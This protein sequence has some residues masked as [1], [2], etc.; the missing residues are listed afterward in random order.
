MVTITDDDGYGRSWSY[1][2]FS[3]MNTTDIR[4]FNVPTPI[5][6]LNLREWTNR[7][8]AGFTAG[9]AGLHSPRTGH[10]LFDIAER[11]RGLSPQDLA[12]WS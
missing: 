2:V 12:R 6:T 8:I 5:G 4:Q 1:R 11:G 10:L 3:R 9:E 7:M